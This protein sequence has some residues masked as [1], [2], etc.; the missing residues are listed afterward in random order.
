MYIYKITNKINNKIYIGQVYNKSIYDRFNRHIKEASSNSKSYVDRAINKYGSENFICELI[1]TANSLQELNQKEI[2]WIN[3]Y[4]S[5]NKNIGYN[6]TPGGDGGN[7]YLCKTK[8]ELDE[9]KHKISI[10]NTGKNNGQSKQIKALNVITKKV[11][12]FDTLSEAC[13]Y[14]NHKQK[15]EFIRHCDH[16]AIALWRKEWTFAYENEDF[17]YQ[18]LDIKY[19]SSCRNG[20]KIKVLDLLDNKEYIFNSLVKLNSLLNI[21]SSKLYS[22]NFDSNN[23]C[24]FSHYKLIKLNKL[25]NKCVSTIPDECKGVG[26]GISTNS[27]QEA[28]D[29]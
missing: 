29:S 2:Y 6:L 22:L 28:I 13:K 11:L 26:L 8:E 16:K 10:N 21:S 18:H 3:Y 20:K 24:Y 7:T 4:N 9:I 25:N 27:K 23:E 1:D 17:Y 15:G 12:H 19:D 5:T 14:F